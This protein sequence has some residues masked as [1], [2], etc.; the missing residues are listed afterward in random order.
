MQARRT[1]AWAMV[2]SSS[3]QSDDGEEAQTRRSPVGAAVDLGLDLFVAA[4]PCPVAVV[5]SAATR[6]DGLDSSRGYSS[7]R[8]L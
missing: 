2:G 8:R 7:S 5:G 3:E 6:R 4:A 1:A